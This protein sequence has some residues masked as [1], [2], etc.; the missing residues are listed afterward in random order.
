[1]AMGM[2]ERTGWLISFNG[3]P[4]PVPRSWGSGIW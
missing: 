1:M 4:N 2:S 3:L